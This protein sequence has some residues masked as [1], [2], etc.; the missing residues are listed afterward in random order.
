MTAVTTAAILSVV[1]DK[2]W[3][4]IRLARSDN[5]ATDVDED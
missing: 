5:E 2:A 3:R 4:S 1:G